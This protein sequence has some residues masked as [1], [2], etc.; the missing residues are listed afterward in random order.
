MNALS[1]LLFLLCIGLIGLG[2]AT[3]RASSKISEKSC[4]D[5]VIAKDSALGSIRN[6]NCETKSL[7][8][9]IK[10]YTSEIDKIDFKDCPENFRLAFND[11][12]NA[13]TAML[14]VTDKHSDLR[15]EMHDLFKVIEQGEDRL[16]FKELL[17]AVWATWGDVE[18]SMK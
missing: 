4:I 18:N 2:C 12:K 15:G 11:H 13:W 16:R 14:E 1:K 17:D 6:H 9:T 8:E 10:I 3:K 5:N 7:S